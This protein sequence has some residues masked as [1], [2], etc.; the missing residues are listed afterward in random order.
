M[1]GTPDLQQNDLEID[2]LRAEIRNERNEKRRRQG[3]PELQAPSC[4]S[5]PLDEFDEA[6]PLFC[7]ALPYLFPFGKAEFRMPHQRSIKLFDYLLHTVRYQ[8]G[9][10]IYFYFI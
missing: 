4:R 10:C 2:Q 6:L 9:R 7:N 1:V 8:H 3:F 5:T